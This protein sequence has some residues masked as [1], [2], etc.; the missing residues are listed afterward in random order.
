M[1]GFT[2]YPFLD[3]IQKNKV[4]MSENNNF[5]SLLKQTLVK[6][7]HGAYCNVS[8]ARYNLQEVLKK[9]GA[10]VFNPKLPHFKGSYFFYHP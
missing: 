6:R 3:L 7:I 4:E 2:P 8:V 5:I 10:L 1:R 9:P